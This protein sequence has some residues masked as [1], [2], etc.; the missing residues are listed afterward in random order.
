MK[1]KT[2]IVNLLIIMLILYIFFKKILKLVDLNL[3]LFFG[4]IS[5]YICIL[6]TVNLLVAKKY[7]QEVVQYIQKDRTN[8]VLATL[9]IS[10]ANFFL[11]F[12]LSSFL[13]LFDLY[14]F[15]YE[16]WNNVGNNFF[17]PIFNFSFS[18]SLLYAL[19]I[20]VSLNN[21]SSIQK[22]EKQ[23]EIVVNVSAQYESLKNQLDPHFL[24]NSL[25]VLSSL[26]EEDQ[27]K[28]VEFTHSL[29]KT[30]RYILEQKD[31]D[32]VPLEQE[33]EFAKVYID[34]LQMRFED[35]LIFDLPQNIEQQGAKVVPLSL[36]LLLENAIKHNKAT[37]Q[38]PI[39]IRIMEKSNGYLVVENNLNKKK[40]L[41]QRQG[42]GLDN[43]KRRYSYL[44]SKPVKVE[45]SEEFFTVSI[46]ILTKVY[47]QMKIID[48]EKT[49]PELI[50]EAKKKVE[51]IKAFYSHLT[52]FIMTNL[53]LV[54]LNL[55]TSPEFLWSLI[56]MFF[57]A[58][59][60]VAQFMKV[61]NYSFFLG[62]NWEEKQIDQ[63]IKENQ[64]KGNKE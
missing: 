61:N 25:N 42:I 9:G 44:S 35:T 27:D 7:K 5:Y 24:F 30:Y 38:E 33:L 16:S 52:V 48:Q 34:L 55:L 14:V 54:G 28:A 50:L 26:I 41:E 2:L 51:K 43:I 59:I 39:T 60:L 17:R 8:I 4:Y 49:E 11:I 31:K 32:L 22:V 53:F 47:E 21:L 10:L 58:I 13:K 1:T 62:D 20:Y 40:I 18:L 6:L 37:E 36:Q 57:W 45:Q 12:I 15:G 64:S 23:K 19:Y 56:V 3:F 46:P 29:S 63:Y